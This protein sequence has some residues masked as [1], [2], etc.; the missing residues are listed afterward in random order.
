MNKTYIKKW[1]KLFNLIPVITSIKSF[2]KSSGTEKHPDG[3]FTFPY[4]IEAG[5]VSEFRKAVSDLGI[6]KPFDWPN[7]EE[8]R[9]LLNNPN[10]DFSSLDTET[11]AN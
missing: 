8:G 9:K 5:V 7:W 3:S 4:V 6:I 2:G 1:Q 10:S 11:L